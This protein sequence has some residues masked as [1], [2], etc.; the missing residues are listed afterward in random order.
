VPNIFSHL[1]TK[2]SHYFRI[3]LDFQRTLTHTV[4]IRQYLLFF[5]SFRS[6]SRFHDHRKPPVKFMSSWRMILVLT[7]DKKLEKRYMLDDTGRHIIRFRRQQKRNMR[8]LMAQALAPRT[9]RP[10]RHQLPA[11]AP[12]PPQQASAGH[13]DQGIMDIDKDPMSI[14]SLL[15]RPLPFMSME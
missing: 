5:Q 7:N 12:L 8:S 4:F 10:P 11:L 6:I 9:A 3:R 14:A 1:P 15:N 2:T 13:I